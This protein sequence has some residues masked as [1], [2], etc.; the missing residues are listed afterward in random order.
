MIAEPRR[1]APRLAG[2][3]IGVT[4]VP[5]DD[6]V[7]DT[8]LGGLGT[9]PGLGQ[10]GDD[11]LQ[12]CQLA[13]CRQG[14]RGD[15]VPK[16]R[17]G[18]ARAARAFPSACCA[19]ED[20][21]AP[22]YPELR[23]RHEQANARRGPEAGRRLSSRALSKRLRA[24]AA[25]LR[26]GSRRARSRRTRTS[27]ATPSRRRST[28]SDARFEARSSTIEAARLGQAGRAAR[29]H[30]RDRRTSPPSSPLRYGFA[31]SRR[32]VPTAPSPRAC[33]SCGT[34]AAPTR[35]G[36]TSADLG[37]TLADLADDH[38]GLDALLVEQRQRSLHR[39]RR[40]GVAEAGGRR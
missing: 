22:D 24:G 35:G 3:T 33:G 2:T 40:G 8:V 15:R 37:P 10:A 16:R 14:R 26:S 31:P 18:R 32:E 7:L 12:R 6:A 1:D 20:Y 5:S 28:S 38:L 39:L 34:P 4:G 19:V 36:P 27:T 29:H 13:R 23:R 9:A 11:R 17:R 21:G 25:R 30:R